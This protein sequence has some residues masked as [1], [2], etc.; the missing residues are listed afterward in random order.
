MDRIRIISGNKSKILIL[1]W[2]SEYKQVMNMKKRIT[3]LFGLGI[4]V[5]LMI[6]FFLNGSTA[7]EIPF[8]GSDIAKIEMYHYE[9]V[10]VEEECKII[11]EQEDI[12]TLYKELQNIKVRDKKKDTEPMTGGSVT[13]FIFVLSDGTEYDLEYFNPGSIPSLISKAGNFEYQT[14]ANI[15][16][17]WTIFDYELSGKEKQKTTEWSIKEIETLFLNNRESEWNLIEC[18]SVYDFAYDRVG[19][20]LFTKRDTECINVAFMDG[21]GTMPYCGVEAVLDENIE[22]T[23]HGNGEVTFNVWLNDEVK[24]KQRIV[25]SKYNDEVKFVSE[26]LEY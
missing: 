3:L 11:T 4:I 26:S 18:V 8:S 15:E 21:E 25:F 13:R 20:V 1:L 9:G 22:F 7:I 16:K 6:S 23:Y 17:F 14:S 12:D 5:G 2:R 24:Y 19:V 10:P